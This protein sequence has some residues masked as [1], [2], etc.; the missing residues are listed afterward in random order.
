M[1][2]KAPP[3][4]EVRAVKRALVLFDTL[5]EIGWAGPSTLAQAT[6]IDRATIYRLLSTMVQAG[7]IVRRA[8]DEKY[9]LS[10]RWRMLSVGIK[11]GDAR[12]TQL[13]ESLARLTRIVKWP[14]D[15]AIISSG[16]LIIVDSTHPQTSMTFFRSVVGKSRPIFR[17]ALGKAMI[18]AMR[19]EQRLDVFDDI[20]KAKGQNAEDLNSRI[21]VNR[22]ITDFETRGYA[23]SVGEATKGICAIALP[24]K[25][26]V[27]VVGAI[28]IVIFQS[29]FDQKVAET[30]LLEELKKCVREA[31]SIF[32]L[33]EAQFRANE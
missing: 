30:K 32:S 13:S 8:Q 22:I 14:S 16:R 33:S 28:N 27:T 21:L 23:L 7:Y 11:S 5:G 12:S 26:E 1:T 6:G 17:S 24:V 25:V 18:G 15:F 4:K 19:T 10:I 29:A 3:Y 31:E 20:R 2:D 9:Y